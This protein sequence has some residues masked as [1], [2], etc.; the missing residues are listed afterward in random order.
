V[1]AILVLSSVVT[2]Q[3]KLSSAS[4]LALAPASPCFVSQA[5]SLP[6]IFVQAVLSL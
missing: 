2:F 6:Q 5:G 3:L 1:E 4:L